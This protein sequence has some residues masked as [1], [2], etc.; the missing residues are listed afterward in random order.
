M[1]MQLFTIGHSTHSCTRF[2]EIVKG[3]GVTTIVDVRSSPFSR[4]F[5]HFNRDAL[6]WQLREQGIHYLF[7]GRELGARRDE[8]ECYVGRQARYDRIEQLPRFRAGIQR[9]LVGCKTQI[10]ALMCAEKDPITCH[11]MVLV[12]RAARQPGLNVRHLREDGS[13]ES[14]TSAETRLL[15]VCKLPTEDLF[16]TRESLIER[17][18]DQQGLR[19]AWQQPLAVE[20]GARD[21]F[22]DSEESNS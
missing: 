17:A 8:R 5:P 2:I 12:S 22:R 14:N 9:L 20:F 11:R 7:L 18:Y 10:V 3:V 19:I 21:V 4:H 13:I 6:Q 16:Q 1:S 15:E